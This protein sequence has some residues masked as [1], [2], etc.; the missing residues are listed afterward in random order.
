M[1][2]YGASLGLSVAGTLASLA[3]TV[4][5]SMSA[6]VL[7]A[8]ARD[9]RS[10]EKADFDKLRTYLITTVALLGVVL[11]MSFVLMAPMLAMS[12][13]SIAFLLAAVALSVY[14]LVVVEKAYKERRA[15][16]RSTAE[17]LRNVMIASAVFAGLTTLAHGQQ[18]AH[19]IARRRMIKAF[20][21]ASRRV[22]ARRSSRKS[23]RRA[24]RSRRTSRR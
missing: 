17:T 5:A 20:E 10:V 23:S 21:R 11:V 6:P 19:L 1:F 13:A 16:P 24:S 22:S 18:S 7:D 12:T 9:P 4:F 15:L 3:G 2:T 8:M 14:A